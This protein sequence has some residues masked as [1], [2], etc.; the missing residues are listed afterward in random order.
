MR[1]SERRTS[2]YGNLK[3]KIRRI[4]LLS[5]NGKSEESTWRPISMILKLIG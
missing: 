4:F 2:V 1:K 3:A 5:R